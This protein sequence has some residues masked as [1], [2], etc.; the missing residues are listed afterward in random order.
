MPKDKLC[1]FEL[2]GPA[3]PVRDA[4]PV[5]THQGSH[6]ALD[7][8]LRPFAFQGGLCGSQKYAAIWTG[9]NTADWGHLEASV[10]MCLH[11]QWLAWRLVGADVGGFFGNPDGELMVR[12]YQAGVPALQEPRPP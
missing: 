1:A 7:S 2:R 8:K 12:W 6:G 9:D 10:P 3:Q 11:S 5:A 4:V